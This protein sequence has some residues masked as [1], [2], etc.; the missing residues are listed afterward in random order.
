MR[1]RLLRNATYPPHHTASSHPFSA[2]QEFKA[3]ERRH[4]CNEEWDAQRPLEHTVETLDD[5]LLRRAFAVK[6]ATERLP[7]F[8]FSGLLKGRK[9]HKTHRFEN[10]GT[11][12]T[13]KT[14]KREVVLLH[15]L[16]QTLYLLEVCRALAVAILRPALSPVHRQQ[17]A[18]CFLHVCVSV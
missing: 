11:T 9:G 18:P 3:L 4:D 5:P 6:V 1:S 10:G 12:Q 17:C 8:P 16:L 13:R 14:G 2:P 15:S 7:V